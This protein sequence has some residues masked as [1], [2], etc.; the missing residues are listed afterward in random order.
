VIFL[1]FADERDKRQRFEAKN[2][3]VEKNLQIQG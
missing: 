3:N 2:G 1:F